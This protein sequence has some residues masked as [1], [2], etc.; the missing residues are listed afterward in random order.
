MNMDVNTNIN[1]YMNMNINLGLAQYLHSDMDL[2]FYYYG[3]NLTCM[4]MNVLNTAQNPKHMNF[5][6]LQKHQSYSCPAL[7]K[8]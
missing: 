6:Q 5:F 7:S 3:V 2:G 8:T 1:I 4:Y